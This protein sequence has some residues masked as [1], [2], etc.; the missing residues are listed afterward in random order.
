MSYCLARTSFDLLDYVYCINMYLLREIVS[1]TSLYERA[2]HL[3]F[4]SESNY[5]AIYIEAYA[6]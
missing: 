6:K 3:L 4:K 2:H 1:I 5:S